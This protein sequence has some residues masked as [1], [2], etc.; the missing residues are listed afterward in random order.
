M[1]LVKYK[2]LQSMVK[3][4]V[5]QLPEKA[6]PFGVL[7]EAGTGSPIIAF[8]MRHEDWAEEFPDEA[9]EEAGGEEQEGV[10]HGE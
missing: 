5:A 2:V 8:M 6:I 9:K 3:D 1:A 4:G 7:S 10:Q